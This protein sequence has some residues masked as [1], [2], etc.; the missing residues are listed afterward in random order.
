MNKER[1]Q[2]QELMVLYRECID[3]M[4]AVIDRDVIDSDNF[5][6]LSFPEMFNPNCFFEEAAHSLQRVITNFST[7]DYRYQ[8]KTVYHDYQHNAKPDQKQIVFPEKKT[9]LIVSEYDG[10]LKAAREF[11]EKYCAN[12]E[13]EY[14][15]DIHFEKIIE[16]KCFDVIMLLENAI[17]TD[18]FLE[19][20]FSKMCG[21]TTKLVHT[22][23]Y[24]NFDDFD[25]LFNSLFLV[26]AYEGTRL[27]QLLI[28]FDDI[29]T[30]ENQ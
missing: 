22:Y 7:D 14:A 6:N 1:A 30:L 19:N 11:A 12:I 3:D 8:N 5:D 16:N 9:V 28:N 18:E 20:G 29:Y 17:Y 23:K 21:E 25:V 24:K 2:M 27:K 26:Y 13:L 10:R 4:L 15:N